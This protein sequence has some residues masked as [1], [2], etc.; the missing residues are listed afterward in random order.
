LTA[1]INIEYS[2]LKELDNKSGINTVCDV[3]CILSFGIDKK[4]T[5]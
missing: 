3:S 4:D 1:A 2:K 5:M